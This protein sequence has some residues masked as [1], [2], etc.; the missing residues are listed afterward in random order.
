ML[1]VL[2]AEIAALRSKAALENSVPCTCG[3]QREAFRDPSWPPP[4]HPKIHPFSRIEEL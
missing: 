2:E 1:E 3:Q 4:G